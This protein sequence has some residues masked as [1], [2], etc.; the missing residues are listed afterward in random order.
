MAAAKTTDR[1]ARRQ[2]V[3]AVLNKARS[4]ELYAITQYMYQHYTLD[5]ADF[6]E[7]A[8]NMKRVAIDEM[9]HAEMFAERIK[10]LGGD[11]TTD[12]DGKVQKKQDVHTIYPFDAATEEDT[13]DAYNQFHAICRENGDTVS[14]KLFETIIDEEQTHHTYFDNVAK[15]IKTL[16]DTYLSKIAGTSASTGATTK[17]FVQNQGAA[18]V[19]A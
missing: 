6:G 9:R 5:D 2:K 19:V 16:G 11:V 8:A 10:D 18:D 1:D 7:L 14:M 4:M 12:P 3:V 15:H 17:G 13:I